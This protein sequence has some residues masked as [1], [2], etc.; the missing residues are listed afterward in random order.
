MA[1]ICIDIEYG[2]YLIN[3]DLGRVLEYIDNYVV[4]VKGGEG[5]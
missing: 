4:E 3:E 2:K 5:E 1:E